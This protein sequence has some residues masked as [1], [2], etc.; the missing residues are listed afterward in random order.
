MIDFKISRKLIH[1]ERIFTC[2]TSVKLDLISK[3]NHEVG[4]IAGD[5]TY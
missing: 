2:K 3:L 4:N 1:E 5:F